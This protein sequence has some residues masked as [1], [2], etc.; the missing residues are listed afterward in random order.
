MADRSTTE[1]IDDNIVW[2]K[3]RKIVN[4][5]LKLE[6]IVRSFWFE[7]FIFLAIVLNMMILILSYFELGDGVLNTLDNIDEY[8]VYFFLMEVILKIIG[9]GF[10][11]YFD[12][13]WNKFDFVLVS[14]S[15]AMNA[16]ISMLKV[17]KNLKSAKSLK[18]IRISK[19]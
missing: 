17:A 11:E 9:L 15:L 12:S 1:V 7:I 19:S 4:K 13:N 14:I 18:F 2:S 6:T 5:Y 10:Q 8:F 3:F 16:T